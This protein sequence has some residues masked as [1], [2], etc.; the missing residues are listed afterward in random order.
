MPWFDEVGA[1]GIQNTFVLSLSKDALPLF[2]HA[3]GM[4]NQR[5]AALLPSRRHASRAPAGPGLVSSAL[6]Y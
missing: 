4:V 2:Q 5:F 6:L 3:A 1:N